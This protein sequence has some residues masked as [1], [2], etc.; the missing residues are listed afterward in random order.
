VPALQAQVSGP[1][2]FVQGSADATSAPPQV[3]TYVSLIDP[4]TAESIPGIPADQFQV[5]EVGT[6]MED[7][8]VEYLPVGLAVVVVV[9]RGGISAPGDPRLR[10]ATD[11][12]RELLARLSVTGAPN[13]DMVAIVGIGEKGVLSPMENFTYNPV[14]IN[15]V[16]NALVVMEGEPLR[17]VTPLYE[18]LDGALSLL[19]ANPDALI[20]K[21]IAHRRKIV[22]VFS[23]GVD[24]NFS[25]AAREEDIIRK[26]NGADISIY[27]VG[28]ARWNRPLADEGVLVRLARQ[29]GGIY[30]LHNNDATHQQVLALMDRLA[31]QRYQYILTYPTRRPKG[32]YTLK[33]E[34]RTD[35]GSAERTLSFS[36]VLE[37][38]QIALIAPS[39]GLAVTVP[40]SRER[41]GFVPATV[42][43]QV[44]INPTDG[45]LRF[46]REVRYLA[47]GVLIG[48]STVSPT[49]EFTWDLSTIVTATEELQ[50]QG[51]TLVAT[52]E[53]AYLG[54][55]MESAPVNIR[56]T[57]EPIQ[58]EPLERVLLWAR[59]NW[60]LLSIWALLT[61]GILVLLVLL[62]RT[63]GELARR[64]IVS[65]TGVLRG[66]T[67]RLG[68]APPHTPA[69]LVVVQGTGIG[70][71]F[72]LNVPLVKVGRDPQ[73]ADFALYDD[74]V[75][76][77][78]FSIQMEQGQCYIVDEGSTNRTFV[79][80][81]PLE[82]FQR[83]PLPPG[84]FIDAGQVRMQL[85]WENHPWSVPEGAAPT[86]AAADTAF[87][88][89][90]EENTHPLREEAAQAP[91]VKGFTTPLPS[92][93]RSESAAQEEVGETF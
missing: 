5:W 54:E 4:T 77:P 6:P 68:M 64:A 85:I 93:E 60:W 28:M 63:R 86:P 24:R 21:T 34:A 7:L 84:A 80:G 79:N 13:D 92:A 70:R 26:A 38:P 42:S 30:Q 41:R 22:I 29:T 49:F 45:V 76:N 56:V 59:T 47:N 57:W 83:V 73:F 8:S 12:V 25:N 9:D 37:C 78:H 1:L 51:F 66:I 3:Q 72:P 90:A 14:D 35:I 87:R 61:L 15:M 53:D 32:D 33:V 20:R 11:L 16:L 27:T 58:Y 50:T 75:S 18:G 67:R 62:I 36:S 43:L 48:S 39:D 2:L 19:I 71:E 31:T 82:P 10:E 89:S 40:Y 88:P 74:Y 44:Q 65:T 17:G 23:D 55:P 52:A 81:A 91:L 46:P 69:K